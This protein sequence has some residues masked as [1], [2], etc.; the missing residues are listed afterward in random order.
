MLMFESIFGIYPSI[1]VRLC[2]PF[3]EDNSPNCYFWAN[4]NGILYFV[5]Y[6]DKKTH[7]NALE[8]LSEYQK[9]EMDKTIEM[10]KQL[11]V[12]DNNLP[13]IKIKTC[14]DIIFKKRNF[15]KRDATYW[16]SYDISR[17]NLEEDGV[18]AVEWFKIIYSNGENKFY[19][20][21]DITYAYTEFDDGVK[22][23][24]PF[25]PKIF[26]W[27]S[28]CS[29]NDVGNIHNL[30]D[31]GRLLIITKAYKDCRILRNLGYHSIWFQSETTIP[32]TLKSLVDRFEKIMIMYDNDNTGIEN[33]KKLCDIIGTKSSFLFVPAKKDLS[34]YV[35]FKGISSFKIFMDEHV[36][37]NI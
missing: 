12:S 25:A 24:R 1:D 17:K 6:G 7:R 28:K 14:T 22:I 19:R 15:E 34:D 2:S 35:R 4:N 32:N 26:K 18:Q 11:V 9:I 31:K 10:V 33:S 21:S 5:D 3:R 30:P 37:P 36:S 8:I 20:P 27:R 29:K 23:Y 13:L 16:S